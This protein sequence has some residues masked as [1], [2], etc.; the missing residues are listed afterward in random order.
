[1]TVMIRIATSD[2]LSLSDYGTSA[3]CTLCG[4][5]ITPGWRMPADTEDEH[6]EQCEWLLANEWLRRTKALD[7]DD[8]EILRL[9]LENLSSSS[10]TADGSATHVWHTK[11]VC[12]ECRVRVPRN[13]E[14]RCGVSDPVPMRLRRAV[15]ALLRQ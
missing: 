12:P 3:F 8:V 11:T 2:P 5:D 4:A 9:A 1:M 10:I 6:A 7:E 13:T 14:H 15:R